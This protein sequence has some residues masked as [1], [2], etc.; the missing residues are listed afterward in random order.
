MMGSVRA[1]RLAIDLGAFLLGLVL[2]WVVV[3]QV[4]VSFPESIAPMWVTMA[5]TIGVGGL[6]A[7]RYR[8]LLGLGIGLA[9]SAILCGAVFTVLSSGPAIS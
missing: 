1:Q 8:A 3:S 9:V 7:R 2:A 5:T 6:A 4:W